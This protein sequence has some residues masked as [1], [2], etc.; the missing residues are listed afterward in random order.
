MSTTGHLLRKWKNG[1]IHL[2]TSAVHRS[3]GLYRERTLAQ[4]DQ[5]KLLTGIHH[6]LADFNFMDRA[7]PKD[8]KVPYAAHK[9]K[10]QLIRRNK[11]VTEH[12][13]LCR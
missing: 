2:L 6:K 5:I 12:I 1:K 3:R 10:S 13:S 8:G 4:I 7:L 11:T 9:N